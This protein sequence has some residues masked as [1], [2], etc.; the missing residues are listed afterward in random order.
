M[1]EMTKMN[2]EEEL[3]RL[4]DKEKVKKMGLLNIIMKDN[5][6]LLEIQKMI[7]EIKNQR[8]REM[9]K[10]EEKRAREQKE[11]DRWRRESYER[12]EREREEREEKRRV[13][14]EWRSIEKIRIKEEKR[15]EKE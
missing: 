2:M 4:S 5:I 9:R 13:D 11:E 12:N 6:E 7:E 10:K 15:A 14:E 8:E 1:G 3:G